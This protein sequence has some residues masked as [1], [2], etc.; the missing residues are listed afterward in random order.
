MAARQG[1]LAVKG[2]RELMRAFKEA[3]KDERKYVREAFKQVGEIV[4]KD[5]ATLFS[6]VDTRSAAGYRVY[7][8]QRGVAVEQSIRKTTGK[9]PE[10]GKLQMR[11][12]LV[13]AL[14]ANDGNIEREMEH[15]LDKVCERFNRAPGPV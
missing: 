7:V 4:R 6:T 13:P 9:H 15:A 11:R 14:V 1:T 12:A 8:R 5:S 10:F 2:Y 3:D